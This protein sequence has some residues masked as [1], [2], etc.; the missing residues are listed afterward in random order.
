MP[1]TRRAAAAIVGAAVLTALAAALAL[2]LGSTTVG[3]AELVAWLGGQ[4]V[5][6]ET[7][8]ILAHVRLPRVAAALLAGSALAVAGFVTQ[9]VLA[10]PMASPNVI[11]VNAGAGLLVLVAASLFPA[12]TWL[13]PVAAFFGA[14][15]SALAVFALARGARAG[16]LTIVLTGMALTAVATAGINV[17]LIVNPDAYVGASRFLVG[18]LAGVM[19]GDLLLP[20]ALIAIGLCAVIAGARGL[21]VIQL[22]DAAAHGLGLGVRRF[23]LGML[24]LAALLAGAAVSFAG[25]LGFVGLIVPHIARV[26]L[27]SGARAQ[28][29]L[30]ALLGALFV[31]AC[32]LGARIAFAPFEI[33]VGIVMA[34]LGG[35]FFV[36]LIVR[37]S[38][39]GDVDGL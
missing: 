22:G 11:G 10:N 16:K 29:A 7:A 19:A 27:R 38:R 3:P 9:T 5:S 25:L 35:P 13:P 23:R 36:A 14:F 2:S 26:L 6:A 24:A 12:A 33:P 32:D 28:L 17:I 30:T 8:A 15:L 37:S 18:G 1:S 21:D 39:R 34:F 20:G 4:P 31:C